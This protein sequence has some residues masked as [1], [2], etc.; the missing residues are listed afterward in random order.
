MIIDSGE[1]AVVE[2]KSTL[3]VNLHTGKPDKRMEL[4]VL[5]TIAGF[6][7]TNGGTLIIG[8]ADD[9]TPVGIEVDQFPNEDKMSLHLINIIKAR[10]GVSAL[11]EV[12]LHF[13]DYRGSRVLVVRCKRSASPVF[14][15]DDNQDR[16]YVRT[17]PS[18]S[19]LRAS[20]HREYI[21]RRFGR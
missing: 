19:E 8:V 18:T 12:H 15:V 16:F 1:S 9:G 13:E 4:A 6:L 7:N 17:G 20:Q 21:Q 5:K 2:L 10:I 3:R 11:S 14:V